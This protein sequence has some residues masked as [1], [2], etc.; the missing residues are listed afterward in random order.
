MF[1]NFPN[2]LNPAILHLHI[3]IKAFGDNMGDQRL[4]LLFE[5]FDEALFFGNQGV[6][7]QCFSI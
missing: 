2:P 3:G 6:D 1:G 7:S 4:T 5:E